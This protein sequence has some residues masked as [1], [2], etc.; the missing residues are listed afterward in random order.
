MLDIIVY[1]QFIVFSKMYVYLFPKKMMLCFFNFKEE[2]FILQN[3]SI[4]VKTSP[5][6][7]TSW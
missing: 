3:S 6:K 2:A 1:V 7:A 4:L 5:Y